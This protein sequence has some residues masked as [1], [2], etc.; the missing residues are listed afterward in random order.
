MTY[1]PVWPQQPD[2][3]PVHS[4]SSNTCTFSQ[5]EFETNIADAEW[6]STD[7]NAGTMAQMIRSMFVY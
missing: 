7:S 4:S 1:F 2:A 6:N 5:A 3:T